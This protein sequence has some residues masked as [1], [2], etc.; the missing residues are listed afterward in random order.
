MVKK[1]IAIIILVIGLLLIF[2]P[3]IKSGIVKYLS[4]HDSITNYSA[5]TLE[6]NNKKQATFD[7][8]SVQLPS[9]KNVVEGAR[10]YDKD[11]VVGSVAVPSVD[12][13]LMVLKGTNTA[14]LLAG[15]TTMLPDQQ[16]GKGNY[17]LAG[18]HMRNESM[19]FGPLMNIKEGAKIYLTDLN[20]LY[21]Y[22]VAS[23]KIVDETD[24]SVLDDAGDNRITL[25]TCD[26]PTETTKRK[27]VV[28]KLT[29]TEKLT[30]ELKNKYFE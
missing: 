1:I 20:T 6:D 28:G 9:M 22:E 18:H 16:M 30:T 23:T 17:P 7:Y 4:G 10:D 25:V 3:F 2:S 21:E 11:A 14:N 5:Q 12:I 26:K 29:H 24:V 27:I 8:D 15:A 19:L 13:K